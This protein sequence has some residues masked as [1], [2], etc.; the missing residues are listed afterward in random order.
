MRSGI[1]VPTHMDTPERW[2][3]PKWISRL[4]RPP[5]G[6][7]FTIPMIWSGNPCTP[8]VGFLRPTGD[9]N[10]SG[11][12]IGPLWSKLITDTSSILSESSLENEECPSQHFIDFEVAMGNPT[13]AI[14][15][16]DCQ[17]MRSRISARKEVNGTSGEVDVK[18]ELKESTTVESTRTYSNIGTSFGNKTD[19]LADS[20]VDAIGNH[21]NINIRCEAAVCG[22]ML[23][24]DEIQCEVRRVEVEYSAK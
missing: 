2:P 17:A 16:T 24:E 13:G 10:T 18:V 8:F 9:N 7:L 19:L 11:W 6:R 3:R 23:S 20:E 1:Y 12:F 14:G 5:R 4:F 21:N 22:D 15:S